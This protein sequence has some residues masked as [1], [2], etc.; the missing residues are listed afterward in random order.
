MAENKDIKEKMENAENQEQVNQKVKDVEKKKNDNKKKKTT[1]SSKKKKSSVNTEMEKKNK[2]IE[3]L[4]YKIS[5]INDKYLRLSAEFDN[6]RKRTLKEKT[7][8]LKTAGGEV[9]SDLLPV[10]DDFERALQSMENTEDIKAVKDGVAL[11]Y[12]KFKDFIK[13]KGIVEIE[14]LNQDFDTDM[15]EALTKIPAPNEKLKGKVVDVIQKGY[16]I[17]DKIIR[18]AKVVVGE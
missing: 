5:E 17:E 9:L 18:Y 8:L 12:N 10:M 3:E 16:K 2:E 7:E 14:A 11:I 15:H 6:Y 13:L 1:S 4:R